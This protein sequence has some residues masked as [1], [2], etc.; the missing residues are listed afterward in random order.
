MHSG[1]PQYLE[2]SR[3]IQTG[4]HSQAGSIPN[5]VRHILCGSGYASTYPSRQSGIRG[6][7]S[8]FL[9][10]V[11]GVPEGVLLWLDP[12]SQAT[13]VPDATP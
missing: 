13:E 7:Y 8:I 5:I 3:G 4:I 12:A 2:T 11:V 10:C 1:G 6:L 9:V